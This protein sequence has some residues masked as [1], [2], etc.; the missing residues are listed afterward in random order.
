MRGNHPDHFKRKDRRD[1]EGKVFL[2][3]PCDRRKLLLAEA[4]EEPLACHNQ[5]QWQGRLEIWRELTLARNF[6]RW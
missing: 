5:R 3:A 2:C 1:R 4:R 6:L